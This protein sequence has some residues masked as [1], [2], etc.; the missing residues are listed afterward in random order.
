MVTRIA[1]GYPVTKKNVVKKYI[2][3]PKYAPLYAMVKCNGPT[4]A[5]IKTPIAVPVEIIGELL[6]QKFNAP[7]IYEVVPIDIGHG[8][9]TR[10]IRLTLENYTKP[11]SALSAELESSETVITKI[12]TDKVTDPMADRAKDEIETIKADKFSTPSEPANEPDDTVN[13]ADSGSE[14]IASQEASIETPKV[15]D[16]AVVEE[17]VKEDKIAEEPKIIVIPSHDEDIVTKDSDVTMPEDTEET[18]PVTEVDVIP[19]TEVEEPNHAPSRKKKKNR[20]N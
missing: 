5:P 10:P 4:T 11:Y 8:K 17:N 7:E 1:P 18:T 14:L 20:H 9:Y 2:K 19:K 6:A 3:I 15:E 13:V 12:M 16:F